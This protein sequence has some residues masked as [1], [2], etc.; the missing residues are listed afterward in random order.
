VGAEPYTDET[1]RKIE[2]GLGLEVYNCYGLSEMNGPGVAFECA[3]KHG[4]HVWE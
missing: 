4:L 3:Q 1:R 2:E